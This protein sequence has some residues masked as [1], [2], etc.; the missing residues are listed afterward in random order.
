MRQLFHH[1]ENAKKVRS[2]L[3]S[4][5]TGTKDK[6]RRSMNPRTNDSD[7][8]KNLVL[9][10]GKIRMQK[11]F[12]VKLSDRFPDHDVT[13]HHQ[14]PGGVSMQNSTQNAAKMA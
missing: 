3:N 12:Y 1:T 14:L 13:P 7:S 8:R 11:D 4:R 5:A 2:Y 10:E 6:S 9:L